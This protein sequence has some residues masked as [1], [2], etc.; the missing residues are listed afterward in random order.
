MFINTIG[1]RRDFSSKFHGSMGLNKDYL[2]RGA[3]AHT[4]P[5]FFFQQERYKDEQ[6]N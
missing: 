4:P 1:R 3:I 6:E 5:A 2:P